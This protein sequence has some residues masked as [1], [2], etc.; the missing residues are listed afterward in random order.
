MKDGIRIEEK[1]ENNIVLTK[2]LLQS[3][4]S[5]SIG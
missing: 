5:L 2:G 3:L 1:T 4:F